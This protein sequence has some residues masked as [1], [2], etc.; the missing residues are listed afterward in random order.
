MFA[1]DT[2][3]RHVALELETTQRE[4]ISDARRLLGASQV[5]FS[6][7]HSA[8]ILDSALD[9]ASEHLLHAH[10]SGSVAPP[11]ALPG[12]AELDL[13]MPWVFSDEDDVLAMVGVGSQRVRSR[14]RSDLLP[15]RLESR[16][17]PRIPRS[18]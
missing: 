11:L 18:R 4:L 7:V 2:L 5:A 8:Q 3:P 6:L 10:L 14:F 15:G 9:A 1:E 16:A 13:E 17:L 12:G